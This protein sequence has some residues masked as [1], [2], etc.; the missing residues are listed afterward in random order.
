[1]NVFSKSLDR[2]Q[3]YSESQFQSV[4]AAVNS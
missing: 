4:H 2:L 1:M 3:I